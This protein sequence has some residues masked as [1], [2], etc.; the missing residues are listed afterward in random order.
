MPRRLT[1]VAVLLALTPAAF[2]DDAARAVVVRAVAA[3]GGAANL[4]ALT[5]GTW[6]T[7]ATVNGNPSRAEFAGEL[8]GQFRLDGSRVV[9]GVRVKTSR[10]IDGDKG[11]VVEGAKTRP[12]TPAELAGGKASFAHKQAAATLTPLLDPAYSLTSAGPGLV[13]GKPVAVVTAAKPGQPPLTLAF[14]AATGLLVQSATT[15]ADPKTGADRRVEAQYS[16]HRD[17]GGVKLAGRTKTFHDGKLF[18]DAEL[19]EFT[20]VKTHPAGTFAPPGPGK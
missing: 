11:W 13:A 1:A 3:T 10:I 19:V 12:M 7:S 5:A 15:D 9:D 4:A 8:P 18:I 20:A 2:A 14:D 6:K 17:F 16:A